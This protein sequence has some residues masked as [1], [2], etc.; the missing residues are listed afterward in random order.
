MT[1][2]DYKDSSCGR[3]N[4]TEYNGIEIPTENFRTKIRKD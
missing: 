1:R 2:H 4:V 3:D